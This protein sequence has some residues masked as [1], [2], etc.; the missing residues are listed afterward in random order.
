MSAPDRWGTVPIGARAIGSQASVQGIDLCALGVLCVRK[1]S[2][3]ESAE[4]AEAL[5]LGGVEVEGR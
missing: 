3:A 2:H 1:M 4:I 5:G